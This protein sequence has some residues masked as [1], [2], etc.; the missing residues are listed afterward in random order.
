M[1]QRS[2][3]F[4]FIAEVYKSEDNKEGRKNELS[5]AICSYTEGIKVKCKN[6]GTNA[7]MHYNRAIAHLFSGKITFLYFYLI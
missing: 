7:K 5:N 1:Q 4:S 3:L 6:D 2:L